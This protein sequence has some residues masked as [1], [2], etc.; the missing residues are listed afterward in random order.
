MRFLEKH[1]GWVKAWIEVPQT[2]LGSASA[3]RGFTALP[4]AWRVYQPPAPEQH[5]TTG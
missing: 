3:A 4:L 5:P 1:F 2:A